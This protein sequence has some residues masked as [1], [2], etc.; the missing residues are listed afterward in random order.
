MKKRRSYNLRISET[1]K[2]T[3]LQIPWVPHY[4]YTLSFAV[5][6]KLLKNIKFWIKK[7]INGSKKRMLL[8]ML[9]TLNAS[10][11]CDPTQPLGVMGRGLHPKRSV[12]TGPAWGDLHQSYKAKRS[13]WTKVFLWCHDIILGDE[14]RQ[15]RLYKTWRSSI[16]HTQIYWVE[17][18]LLNA[19]THCEI[20]QF[21][22]ILEWESLR[23]PQSW[24]PSEM[25][26]TTPL[27]LILPEMERMDV[28]S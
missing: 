14:V 10:P 28:S 20:R 4:S 16:G 7:K 22:L 9:G 3:S 5:N 27:L 23:S 13:E 1:N 15:L 25:H 12:C 6:L 11:F 2:E 8:V 19:P 21:E 17:I 24:Q 26:L 18:H